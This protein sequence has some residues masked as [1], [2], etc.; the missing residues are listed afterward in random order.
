MSTL[1]VAQQVNLYQPI[2]GAERRLFSAQAIALALGVLAVSL[3]ALGGYASRRVTAVERT[4]DAIEQREA[5]TLAMTEQTSQKFQPKST[6]AELDAEAKR[7][8]VAIDA[9][10]HALDIVKRGREMPGMGFA[11]RLEALGNR[12]IDGIWLSAISLNAGAD[13][14]AMRGAALRPA[15]VPTYLSGLAEETALAGIH[16]DKLSMRHASEAERP[17][18]V[19]FELDSAKLSAPDPAHKHDHGD[20]VAEN[21]P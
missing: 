16:F 1:A 6:Q 15:L 12:Q 4:V 3:V 13:G 10:Q 2:L 11:A 14:L 19:V 7:L 18:Q 8:S 5:S 20:D 17:A 9:R 21:L